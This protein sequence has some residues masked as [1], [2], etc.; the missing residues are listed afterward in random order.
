MKIN[1]YI[2][3]T[4][5]NCKSTF[6]YYFSDSFECVF[7]LDVYGFLDHPCACVYVGGWFFFAGIG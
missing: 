3:G 1:L 6:V 7:E 2:Q 5:V 4:E